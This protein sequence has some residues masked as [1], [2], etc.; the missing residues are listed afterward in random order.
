MLGL[1]ATVGIKRLFDA[2]TTAAEH[3]AARDV[4]ATKDTRHSC[5]RQESHFIGIKMIGGRIGASACAAARTASTGT[6]AL[7]SCPL[8]LTRRGYV[9]RP[10]Q[11]KDLVSNLHVPAQTRPALSE[12][13]AALSVVLFY[14]VHTL[15][16]CRAQ[17]S[18][19]TCRSLNCR[20]GTAK[21]Q[22][23]FRRQRRS[24]GMRARRWGSSISIA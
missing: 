15:T 20:P 22:L 19:P 9:G 18:L 5:E 13:R 10:G 17:L 1:R 12:T 4:P 8:A 6:G 23:R 3:I 14:Q 2:N 24:T 7:G 11:P 21:E 16:D